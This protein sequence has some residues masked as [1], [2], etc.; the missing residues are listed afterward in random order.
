SLGPPSPDQYRDKMQISPAP[1]PASGPRQRNR[2]SPF[3]HE[4]ERT[5][6]SPYRYSPRRSTRAHSG[7]DQKRPR[8]DNRALRQLA[9]CPVPL[10]RF[11]IS[12]VVVMSAPWLRRVPPGASLQ[13]FARTIV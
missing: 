8:R 7:R 12:P 6:A 13:V 11:W 10:A 3:A 5:N 2:L 1:A 4:Y 9:P